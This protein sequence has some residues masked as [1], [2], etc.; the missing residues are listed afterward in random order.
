MTQA[1]VYLDHNATSPLRLE[2]REVMLPWLGAAFGN[3]SSVHLEGRAARRAFEAARASLGAAFGARAVDVVLTAGATEANNQALKGLAFG[4]AAAERRRL[5]VS[6]VEHPSVLEPARWLQQTFGFELVSVPVDRLGRLDWRT[7]ESSVDDQTLVVS[8]IAANNETGTI[9]PVPEIAELCHGHGAL[10][11]V[12]ATQALGRIAVDRDAWGA[13][14]LTASSH[15]VGGPR[16]AG[17]L[18]LSSAA[19]RVLAPL[20]HGGHQ[21]RNRRGGTEDVAAV[22]G[23]AAAASCAVAEQPGEAARL[24]DLRDALWHGLKTAVPDAVRHG[25]PERVLPNTL[26]VSFPGADGETLLIGLDLDGVAASS[27]SA[28]TAGSL[29]PSHVLLAMGVPDELARGAV[30]FSLGPSSHVDA[31]DRVLALVPRLVERARQEAA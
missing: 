2:A 28:C 13:D 7:L 29:E 16:G 12:D 26:N 8:I 18:V 3:P 4:P 14:L 19:R 20:L 5:V 9:H 11:H 27:G 6:A 24:A 31:I 25:D 30:R 15:K 22:V 1:R 17:A 21:E 10:L 23:F